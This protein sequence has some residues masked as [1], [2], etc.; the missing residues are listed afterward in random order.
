MRKQSC[1]KNGVNIRSR[2]QVFNSNL[3]FG[4]YLTFCPR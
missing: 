1:Y 3:K 4:I 2:K